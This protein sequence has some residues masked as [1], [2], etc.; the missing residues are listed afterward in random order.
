MKKLEVGKS[1]VGY[2]DEQPIPFTVLGRKGKTVSVRCD[3]TGRTMGHHKIMILPA[4][5]GHIEEPVEYIEVRNVLYGLNRLCVFA[6]L[7]SEEIIR[8]RIS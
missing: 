2:D 5:K 4:C 8:G 7:K 1:Y 3:Y 6:S